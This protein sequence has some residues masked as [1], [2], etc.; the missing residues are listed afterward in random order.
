MQTNIRNS[1]GQS[2]IEYLIIVAII[3]VGSIGIVKTLGNTVKVRFANITNALQGKETAIQADAP[4]ENEY[5]KRG[6]D[7]F[8]KGA[9]H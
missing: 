7:D 6:L 9:G 4:S 3:A 2:L 1:R 8:F 5:Q